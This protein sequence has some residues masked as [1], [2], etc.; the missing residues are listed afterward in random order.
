MLDSTRL[1]GSVQR[2]SG[3]APFGAQPVFDWKRSTIC[4]G[5]LKPPTVER[6]H[7]GHDGHLPNRPPW[8]LPAMWDKPLSHI[9]S[10]TYSHPYT[11]SS[12]CTVAQP[13]SVFQNQRLLE[14]LTCVLH[15]YTWGRCQSSSPWA[16]TVWPRKPRTPY[17][18]SLTIVSGASQQAYASSEMPA[19]KVYRPLG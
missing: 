9:A 13:T 12:G 10:S 5:K 8:T 17:A 2:Q 11:I 15:S 3:A 7:L 18:P 6:R 16:S 19:W 1:V 14:G 4:C